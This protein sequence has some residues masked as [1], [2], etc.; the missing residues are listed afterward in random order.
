MDSTVGRELQACRLPRRAAKYHSGT[1]SRALVVCRAEH[2]LRRQKLQPPVHFVAE[3][4]QRYGAKQLERQRRSVGT[5]LIE[6]ATFAI[7]IAVLRP[8]SHRWSTF[9]GALSFG[10]RPRPKVKVE[11]RTRN[12]RAN[13][14]GCSLPFANGRT[15]PSK[16]SAKKLRE[17]R[18]QVAEISKSIARWDDGEAIWL[19]SVDGVD[20]RTET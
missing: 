11:Y 3:R 7:I 4:D 2:V 1:S 6:D 20:A 9:D 14:C 13:G 17:A 19:A 15:R 18:K 16:C 8:K 10:R 5:I 12:I